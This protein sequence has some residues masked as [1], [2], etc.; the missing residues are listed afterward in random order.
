MVS[1]AGSGYKALGASRKVWWL[2]E[3]CGQTGFAAASTDLQKTAEVMAVVAHE[4]ASPIC[5]GS[6][7]MGEV[8]HE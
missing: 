7:R 8:N 4:K 6:V 1:Y 5:K 2:C 3:T